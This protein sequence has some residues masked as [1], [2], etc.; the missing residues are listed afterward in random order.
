M[1]AFLVLTSTVGRLLSMQPPL[2]VLSGIA[3]HRSAERN[4]RFELRNH[5]VD[6]GVVVE[7]D[8]FQSATPVIA[9]AA[10]GQEFLGPT[11]EHPM[12]RT[13]QRAIAQLQTET[14][15]REARTRSSTQLMA[16]EP[17]AAVSS[18]IMPSTISL[19]AA[20]RT[21]SLLLK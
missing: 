10:L 6:D 5:V 2:G 9:D 15:R 14:R 18:S 8:P 16:W 21:S 12:V 19:R 17:K 7:S 3:F 4:R 1:R 20:T 13:P 11:I